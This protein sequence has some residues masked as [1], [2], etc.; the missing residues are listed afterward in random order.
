MIIVF[1]FFP[2]IFDEKMIFFLFFFCSC[3]SFWHII[4]TLCPIR[5]LSVVLREQLLLQGIL[6]ID[7]EEMSLFRDFLG[8]RI[9][10]G[11]TAE[12]QCEHQGKSFLV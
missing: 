12:P 8:N 10:S 9:Y 11:L 3:V 1:P 2:E 6:F 7:F 5:G 4:N